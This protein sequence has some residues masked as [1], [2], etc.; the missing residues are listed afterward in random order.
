M[1]KNT[2]RLRSNLEGID[3][4]KAYNLDEALGLLKQRATAKFDETIEV[5]MNLGI[6]PRH[7]DQV[8]RGAVNLPHGTGKSLRVAVFA[9]G[10]KAEEAQA[11]GA[12]VVGAEDLAERITNGQ[13]DFDRCIATPDM[14]PIVGK[15]G[16]VLGP[17]GLMP[18]PKLGTVTNDVASAVG[19]AKAG[20][21]QFRA[22]KAGI[23]HAEIGRA[24]CRE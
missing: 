19:E 2:K 4:N 14:M 7:A 17:R 23:V 9:R 3:R 13:I 1:A 10:A 12:D 15:L 8:V 21:V 5:S 11:A 22:E 16:R 20:Q 18:N 24:S 6:D